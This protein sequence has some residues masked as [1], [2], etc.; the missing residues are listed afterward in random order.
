MD[1]EFSHRAA[2][3]S[4]TLGGTP[5]PISAASV[6]TA[7]RPAA[8]KL[9]ATSVQAADEFRFSPPATLFEGNFVGWTGNEPRTVHRGAQRPV[10]HVSTVGHKPDRDAY[11]RRAQLGART[12]G[13]CGD[14][15][16]GSNTRRDAGRPRSGR[17]PRAPASTASA[18]AY[19]RTCRVE[20]SGPFQNCSLTLPY[21]GDL[22]V[23]VS[24]AKQ[25][26]REMLQGLPDDA[27]LEDIQYHIYVK[28]KVAL[29]LADVR[30]GRVISQAEI[31]KRFARWLEK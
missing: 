14:Q 11:H 5:W 13:A 29:G 30:A 3:P 24:T 1:A 31:E 10:P 7:A 15:V 6:S 23:A 28:Q 9:M 17:L 12:A 27:T 18:H 4:R 16:E 20:A 19:M 26:V 2:A 22:E 8:S 25:E 21:C